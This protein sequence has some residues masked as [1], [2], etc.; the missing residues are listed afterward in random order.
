MQAEQDLDLLEQS[1]QREKRLILLSIGSPRISSMICLG[2][3]FVDQLLRI[4]FKN[5]TV[6]V[7]PI[8]SLFLLNK[9]K[10]GI[11]SF[12]FDGSAFLVWNFHVE[13][14]G[15]SIVPFD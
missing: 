6:C 12:M 9:S 5:R 7:Y 8:L 2:V 1:G 13:N 3:S 15:V 14:S 11:P 4:L 10:S